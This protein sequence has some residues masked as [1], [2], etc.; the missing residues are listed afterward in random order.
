MFTFT[1]VQTRREPF[2]AKA[3]IEPRERRTRQGKTL[4]KA[5][6]SE[7]VRFTLAPARQGRA[8][9]RKNILML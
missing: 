6:L 9:T 4:P 7:P 1:E 8:R 3:T 2:R 5:L